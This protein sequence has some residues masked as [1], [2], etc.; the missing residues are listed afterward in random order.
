MA[1]RRNAKKEKA[2]RNKAYARQFRKQ[3]SGS[4]S[5]GKRFSNSEKKSDTSEENNLS[6]SESTSR[7]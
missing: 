5:G 6:S 4:Y 7:A 2:S 1:K 3:S